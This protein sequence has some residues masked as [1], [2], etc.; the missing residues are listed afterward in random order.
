M[1]IGFYWQI[2]VFYKLLYE[3]LKDLKFSDGRLRVGYVSFD[4]GNYFIF[5]F[6]Q[7][8]LGMY[9]FDKFEVRL[10]FFCSYCL[11]MGKKKIYGGGFIVVIRC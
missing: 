9:N 6:M 2:N 10:V 7:F 3:Y 4:F 5:Y 1:S 11:F 8:I